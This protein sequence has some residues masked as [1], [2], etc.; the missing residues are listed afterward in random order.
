MRLCA[1]DWRHFE[2]KLTEEH[3]DWSVEKIAEALVE[4]AEKE[5][6]PQKLG[7]KEEPLKWKNPNFNN[8]DVYRDE[9]GKWWYKSNATKQWF[10]ADKMPKDWYDKLI[11]DMAPKG[12]EQHAKSDEDEDIGLVSEEKKNFSGGDLKKFLNEPANKKTVV[13]A[14]KGGYSTGSIAK[15]LGLPQDK[16][17]RAAIRALLRKEGIYKELNKQVAEEQTSKAGE[18]F[19]ELQ[20]GLAGI[21]DKYAKKMVSAANAFTH[22]QLALE[23]YKEFNKEVGVTNGQHMLSSTISGWTGSSHSAGAQLMKYMAAEYYGKDIELEPKLN[24]SVSELKSKAEPIKKAFM[25][26]KEFTKAWVKKH[27]ASHVYRGLHGSIA[28]TIKKQMK[29]GKTEIEF[30]SNV[31]SSWSDSPTTAKNFSGGGVVLRMKVDPEH[32]WACYGSLPFSNFNGFQS[33]KEYVM[34]VP[35]PTLKIKVSD[36]KDA[37]GHLGGF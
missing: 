5:A 37:A 15:S 13:S 25:A 31:L 30:S 22:K 23:V 16:K 4:Q 35:T 3:P 32:V 8:S 28:E 21:A 12:V 14:Y 2:A 36:I 1:R 11:S 27:G 34:G 20:S 7:S 17:S 10:E 19:E 9:E 26:Q 18:K 6:K 24:T 33:E 29:E